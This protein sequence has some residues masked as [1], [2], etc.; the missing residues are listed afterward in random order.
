MRKTGTWPGRVVLRHGLSKAVARPW[1]RD[2]DEAHLALIRGGPGFLAECGAELRTLG[3]PAV[4][5]P[6]L[7]EHVAG[8]W[9]EAGYRPAEAL[10]VF[11]RDL[12]ED[13]PEADRPT[14]VVRHPD[15]RSIE[16]LDRPAFEPR[17]RLDVDGLRDAFAAT[18]VAAVIVTGDPEPV[19]FAIVGQGAIAGYLQRIAVVPGR[20]GEGFG[21]ALVRAS[22]RWA[23]RRGARHMLLNTL[24]GNSAAAKLYLDE[25]FERLD[26]EL[27]LYRYV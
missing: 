15:W 7:P 19:G 8:P 21:R 18:P 11:S 16:D 20:Q 9:V 12:T 2:V 26:D 3:A 6:P 4:S 17:W 13:I 1:N 10:E 14:R 27:H 24:P 22:L 5:S 23:K 25:G